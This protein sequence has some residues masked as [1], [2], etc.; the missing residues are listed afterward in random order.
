MPFVMLTAVGLLAVGLACGGGEQPP[1]TQAP[2][3]AT[4]AS[5]FDATPPDI[6]PCGIIT[7]DDASAL[8]GAP[9]D[10]GTAASGGLPTFC[11]YAT[12]DQTGHLSVNIGY[13]PE[14]AVNN[15]DDYGR[16]KELDQDVPGLG[17][18]A[19]YIVEGHLLYAAK[20]PWLVHMSGSVQ[21]QPAELD[22]L[23]PLMQTALGRLP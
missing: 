15:Y 2:A 18:G 16:Y 23:T 13:Y 8:F 17:D 12:A 3:P 1:S 14:G 22:K 6:A 4:E 10:A 5:A 19:F 9:S 7:Q 21:A 11:L 20:G